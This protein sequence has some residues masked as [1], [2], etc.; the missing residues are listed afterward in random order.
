M[1]SSFV[2]IL[3]ALCCCE[4]FSTLFALLDVDPFAMLLDPTGVGLE[5]DVEKSVEA[6][7]PFILWDPGQNLFWSIRKISAYCRKQNKIL[8][9]REWYLLEL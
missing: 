2:D 1:F 4:L 5:L 9:T 6:A 8:K 3:G 7:V